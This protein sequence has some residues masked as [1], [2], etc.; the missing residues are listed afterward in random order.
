MSALTASQAVFT[1]AGKALTSNAITGTGN[2]VM[3]ASP[4]LTGTVSA[5]AATL[6]SDLTL[7]GG[8]AN[9]VLYLNGSKVATSGS[10]LVFD[11]SGNLGLG[12]TPSAWKTDRKAFQT[13]NTSLVGFGTS[14]TVIYNNSYVNSSGNDT[15]ISSASAA[16]YAQSG[17]QHAWYTAASGTAGNTITFTQAMTLDASGNLGLGTTTPQN[18]PNYGGFTINGTSGSVITLRSG[19]SNSGRIY[20]TTVDNINIDANGSASG[21]IIFRNGT[22]STERARITSG[23]SFCVHD[24]TLVD[25]GLVSFA[26]TTET[27]VVLA[28]KNPQ[29]SCDMW[30][31][32]TSGD[33]VWA[34]FFSETSATQRGSI[35]YNRT[36]GLV[37]YNT[38]SDYRAKDILGPVTDSGA[39]IDALK[40]YEG[41]MKGATQS[42]PM[43]VAHEAQALAPYA[44]TGEKDAVD[45]DGNPKYQQMDVSS[46][47]PLLIA[48]IQSLRQRVAQLEG[49][50]P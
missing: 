49:T 29:Y 25:S 20:T 7:S 15:Y 31:T 47:V 6:S 8:T 17:A 35:S 14:L 30:A 22:G 44:V 37:A 21:T 46:F 10:G 34:R 45:D 42:R 4:T 38:T 28:I 36:G 2:V 27:S 16:A 12:V 48:E 1:T 32:N 41:K 23:G 39:T 5:A 11:S 13:G 50:Q 43:L 40:V 19:G 9:G 26:K 3:S 18:D 33:N 24:G